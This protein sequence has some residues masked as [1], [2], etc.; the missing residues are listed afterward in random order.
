MYLSQMRAVNRSP[1]TVRL[2]A[3]YLGVLASHHTDPWVVTTSD[4]VALMNRPGWG[5]DAKRSARAVW[6]GFY[7][8][9]H[10]TGLC[11]SW[12]GEQMPAVKMP[13]RL[14]RPAPDLVVRRATS[15][16]RARMAFMA[17]LAAFA[18][19]RA[20]EIAAVHER[21][22]D[23]VGRVLLVHGKGSKERLVPI[24]HPALVANLER[25]EGWAFPSTEESRHLTPGYV[26]KLLSECLGDWSAHNLRHRFAT[27]AL[28]GT[29]DLLAVSQLLGHAS[30][31]TT[32]VYTALS[33]T[34]LRAA[35]RAAA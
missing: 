25:V 29:G 8:W 22:Y 10:G 20:A 14:P 18:G 33:T 27:E 3:H 1:L 17:Q 31:A 12:I 34:K 16:P 7:R 24:E 4:L 30:V 9:A 35:V 11:E 5:P 19:M 23:R 2:H 26:T 28:D 15:D 13:R 21:D 32:Q 6:R